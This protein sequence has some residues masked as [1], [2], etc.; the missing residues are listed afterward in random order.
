MKALKGFWPMC[1]IIGCFAGGHAVMA[2]GQLSDFIRVDQFG[3]RPDA[4]KV[5]VVADPQTGFDASQH[6]S[7]GTEP[8]DYQLRN[9]ADHEP[10]FSGA[11]TPWKNGMTD[12]SSGDK[13]WWFDFSAFNTPGQYYVY[14]KKN[15]ARSFSFTIADDVYA[16]VLRVAL[17][18]FYYNRCNHIK[19]ARYVGEQWEDEA[20]FVGAGQD[21]A[22]R[23]VTDRGNAATEKN[24]EGG[25]WDAGDYNK[26][27]TFSRSAMH[28]LLDA[29]TQHPSIWGDNFLTE[30]SGNGIP[31]IL[32]EIKWETDWLLRMQLDDGGVLLKMG[33]LTGSDGQASLPPSKDKRPRYYYPGGCSSAT[34]TFASVMAHA[35]YVFEQHDATAAYA[36]VLK[37]KAVLAF[38]HYVA[39]G[40]SDNCDD[41]TIQAGDADRSLA[42]QEQIKVQAAVYLYA[43][44][45]AAEYREM[46]QQEFGSIKM[47]VDSW[48]GPYEA[49]LGD[50]LMF[51]TALPDVDPVVVADIRDRRK[52]YS[53]DTDLYTF[54]D[55]DPYRAHLKDYVWGSNMVRASIANINYD[56]VHYQLAPDPEPY[57]VRAEEILHYFHGVNP[58]NTVYLTNMQAYGAERSLTEIYHSWF[59]DGSMWDSSVTSAGGGPAPG[60]V[61][62]GPNATYRDGNNGCTLT[63]PCHQ[64]VQKSYRD[65]NGIWP[66]ASWSVTEPAIYYQAAYIK[67]LAHV[68]APA[69]WDLS[70]PPVAP[71]TGMADDQPE[72]IYAYPNP[73]QGIA[74]L[75]GSG[76]ELV[77]VL[78]ATG[79]SV[80][81]KVV[82]FREADQLVL[83]F[84]RLENGVYFIHTQQKNA[85]AVAK[86]CLI[87]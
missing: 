25:W 83:D 24:L 30:D 34:I 12:P 53:Q 59:K 67:A 71:V 2:Q 65:W 5:A 4:R 23:S 37:D 72:L 47:M 7:P 54:T 22:V 19:Q 9:A 69:S 55:K 27:V 52:S 70:L 14:D 43:I 29:Y 10:V 40:K 62:G 74:V 68:A 11:V 38:Q 76:V 81:Y 45:G 58:F 6:F 86:V 15:N 80:K 32:D 21:R 42:E 17:R 1:M 31:D 87:R 85:A 41:G 13:A 64:P 51:F 16:D 50:A 61:P 36:S 26:Y 56:Y 44:T 77:D 8:G 79:S 48:W 57:R 73:S 66:D 82:S 33:T 75:T 18:M 39:N 63:P 20:S 78:S 60:Y 84:S 3:Y 35:A 49:D 28:F 46:V